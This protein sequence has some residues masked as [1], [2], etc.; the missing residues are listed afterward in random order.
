MGVTVYSIFMGGCGCL[1]HFYGSVWV[2][3]TGCDWVWVG[4]TG[5]GMGG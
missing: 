1:E 2:G 5:C 4:M 3:V